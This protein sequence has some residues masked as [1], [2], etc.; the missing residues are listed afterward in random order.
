MK[1]FDNPPY[2]L[3]LCLVSAHGQSGSV[4]AT[5]LHGPSD[6]RR[7]SR[8]TRQACDEQKHRKSET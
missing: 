3:F 6:E 1:P 4:K 2:A 8:E 5:G 7:V